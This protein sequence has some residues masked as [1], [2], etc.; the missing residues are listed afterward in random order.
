MGGQITPIKQEFAH[1][2]FG[3][4]DKVMRGQGT[5]GKPAIMLHDQTESAQCG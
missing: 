4:R 3:A 2:R 1:V 5:V